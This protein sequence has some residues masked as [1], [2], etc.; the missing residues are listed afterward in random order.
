M[1]LGGGERP[2]GDGQSTRE[3]HCLIPTIRIH[4][5]FRFVVMDIGGGNAGVRDVTPDLGNDGWVFEA[6]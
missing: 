5:T 3:T 6:S 4:T 1:S 2:S